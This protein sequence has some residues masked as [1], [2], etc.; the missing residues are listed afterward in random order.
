MR[1]YLLLTPGPLTTTETVK[2]A[3][4]GDWCT[5]DDD[6][7]QGI[8]QNT[9]A[10]LVRLAASRPDDYTAVLLQGSGTYCVEATI[11]GKEYLGGIAGCATHETRIDKC[12][13][14]NKAITGESHIGGILGYSLNGSAQITSNVAV[15]RQLAAEEEIYRIAPATANCGPTG[16]STENRAWVLTELILNDT[17]QPCPEDG[18]AHGTNTGLSALRLKATYQ[19][20]GWDFDTDWA[21][22]ENE[23]F[24]YLKT[25]TAPP[26]FAQEPKAG[27]TR[28]GGSCAEAGT[29][30]VRVGG[31]RYET[32]SSGSA[33]SIEV[34][35]LRSGERMEICVQAGGKQPS[36]VVTATV[37]YPGSGTEEDPYLISTASELQRISDEGYYLLTCDLDLSARPDGNAPAEGWTPIGGRGPALAVSLDG[38]G[39]TLGGLRCN[40]DYPDCGLFAKIAPGGAVRDLHV[41]LADGNKYAATSR[42]GGIAGLDKGRISGCEVIGTATGATRF[43]R[44][45]W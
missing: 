1:P 34:D 27:D 42:F 25:Q 2:E 37:A 8:V 15:N 35:T 21:I 6:Y 19:G 29:V 17:I 41:T 9:R 32:Q 28:L 11:I 39:H 23:C 3:M 40:P 36:Y 14:H 4:M 38:G 44:Q 16:T 43:G 30:S 33:W 26:H 24:P 18:I 31:R 13:S 12:Y 5:W 20:L 45:N 22:Q 7:N 10:R